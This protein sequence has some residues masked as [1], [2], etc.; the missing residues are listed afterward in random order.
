MASGITTQWEDLH[1]KAGNWEAREKKPTG[2]EIFK[3]QL[4]FA[5]TYDRMEEKNLEQLDELEDDFEDEFLKE[6]REK[7][8]ADLK[9]KAGSNKYGKVIEINKQEW[10]H[11]ITEAEKGVWALVVLY[12]DQ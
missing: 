8:M 3:G 2:A 5:E 12:Q 7:R 6:Y 11:Q 1:V 10:T 4:E 9:E